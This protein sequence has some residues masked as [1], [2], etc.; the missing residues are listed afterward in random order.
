VRD[1]TASPLAISAIAR[2]W[3]EAC[4]NCASIGDRVIACTSPASKTSC[5]FCSAEA[6]RPHSKRI[7]SVLKRTSKTTNRVSKRP[8]PPSV[9]YEPRLIA[10]LKDPHEA[11]AY[12]EAAIED[13]DQGALMLALRHVAQAQGG[14][15]TVA[16]KSKLTREA[17]YRMLSEKGNP[18]LKNLTAVLA[19]TG[20]QLSVK[21]IGRR[22][23]KAA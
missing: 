12:L 7:F 16:R 5:C 11:A 3:A 8:A 22:Q 4:R 1:L 10:S 14:V 20:L 9:P 15:A 17:T 18:E 19:A 21:P 23:K 13:G 6:T 2:R